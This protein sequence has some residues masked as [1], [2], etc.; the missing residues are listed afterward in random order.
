[1]AA[2]F[3]A[4]ADGVRAKEEEEEEEGRKGKRMD[5]QAGTGRQA[6][7]WMGQ[8]GR[9]ISCS[10][11][12]VL[13]SKLSISQ[14]MGSVEMMVMM[15]VTKMVMAKMMMMMT[16]KMIKYVDCHR[17]EVPVQQTG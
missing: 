15:M 7:G 14:T 12:A 4:R 16:V 13:S 11:V 9:S 8:A 2:D 5:E 6:D 3:D 1:M 17:K 10:Q